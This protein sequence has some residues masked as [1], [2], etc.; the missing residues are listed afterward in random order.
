MDAADFVSP[1]RSQCFS[2]GT[3]SELWVVDY[4][5]L[6]CVRCID[7]TTRPFPYRWQVTALVAI[8]RRAPPAARH[9]LQRARFVLDMATKR[10]PVTAAFLLAVTKL[11]VDRLRTT[12]LR[13][14]VERRLVQKF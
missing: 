5:R 3:S 9:D 1:V 12:L 10:W 7:W 8:A 6:G 13:L 2:C 14:N 4:P 11:E